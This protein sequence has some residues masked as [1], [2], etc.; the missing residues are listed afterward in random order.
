MIDSVFIFREAD[1]VRK[2]SLKRVH[3]LTYSC[4]HEFIRHWHIAI[5]KPR[6]KILNTENST[7][8]SLGARFY[9]L[10]NKGKLD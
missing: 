9:R 2:K 1:E 8:L 5:S 3:E 7:S 10:P 6:H 4:T